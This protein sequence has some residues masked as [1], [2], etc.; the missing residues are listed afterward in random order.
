RGPGETQLET[1]RRLVRKR[2]GDLK[3]K[4]SEIEGERQVQ[5]KGRS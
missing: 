5:R 4:L 2:I 3:K 1:D